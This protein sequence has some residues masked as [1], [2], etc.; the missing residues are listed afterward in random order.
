MAIGNE[1]FSGG[2]SA[3]R[4]EIILS[5]KTASDTPEFSV[6]IPSFNRGPLLREAVESVLSQG[7]ADAEVIVIDDG[8]T[9]DTQEM[10]RSFGNAVRIVQQENQGPERSRNTGARMAGGPRVIMGKA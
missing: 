8:S 4:Q 5:G 2:Q 9:D 10:L 6:V 3:L 7:A 1:N